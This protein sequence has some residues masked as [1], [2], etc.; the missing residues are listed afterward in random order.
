MRTPDGGVNGGW[1]L[2]ETVRLLCRN[3]VMRIDRLI[4]AP[5]K[6]VYVRL[7]SPD[8]CSKWMTWYAAA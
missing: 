6:N 3:G 8:S 5:L 1:W 2:M 4:G 7:S